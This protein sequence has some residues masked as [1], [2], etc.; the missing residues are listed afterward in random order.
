FAVGG[1]L[2]GMIDDR[3]FR[4][5][6]IGGGLL[7]SLVG[8]RQ[9][10]LGFEVRAL[11]FEWNGQ[12]CPGVYPGFGIEA[13]EAREDRFGFV[14]IGSAGDKFSE[15]HFGA[16]GISGIGKGIHAIGGRSSGAGGLGS[17]RRG[18]GIAQF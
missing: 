1:L 12:F 13:G 9:L 10:A 18:E 4:D 6:V 17:I 15:A 3:E 16:S 2:C 11:L 7:V 8:L 14:G 5:A